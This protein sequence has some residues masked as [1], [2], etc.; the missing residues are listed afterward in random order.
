MWAT[1]ASTVKNQDARLQEYIVLRDNTAAALNRDRQPFEEQ[2]HL[3]EMQ[4]QQCELTKAAAENEMRLG[5]ADPDRRQVAI[6]ARGL[7]ADWTRWKRIAS[8]PYTVLPAITIFF[9]VHSPPRLRLGRSHNVAAAMS[10]VA[11]SLVQC[12]ASTTYC[13]FD[14]QDVYKDVIHVL[15]MSPGPEPVTG[16]NDAEY[17]MSC[18]PRPAQFAADYRKN[19]NG[20]PTKKM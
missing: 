15:S 17:T 2:Q 13:T 6:D 10:E 18:F 7:S 19:R 9:S 16:D 12:A 3:H 1:L 11:I 14:G 4:A 8:R 20:S 5:A